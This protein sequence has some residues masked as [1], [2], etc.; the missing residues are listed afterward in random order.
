MTDNKLKQ[1]RADIILHGYKQQVVAI[2]IAKADCYPAMRP[3]ELFV[4][5]SREGWRVDSEYLI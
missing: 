2:S 1:L 3:A 5:W 4:D